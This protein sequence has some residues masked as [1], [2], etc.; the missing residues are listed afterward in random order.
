[1]TES[2][3]TRFIDLITY[4]QELVTLEITVKK[5]EQE[6]ATLRASQVKIVEHVEA[7]KKAS[8]DAQKAVDEKELEMATLVQ[9]ETTKKRRL[10]NVTNH[11]EYQSIKL[12][13][14]ALNTQQSSL[15]STLLEAWDAVQK[16]QKTYEQTQQSSHAQLEKLNEET[17][18]KQQ[19]LH[20]VQ[21]ELENKK[22][23]RSALES[24]VPAEWLEK[25]AVMRA[26]VSDPVVPVNSGSCSACFYKI[27]EQDLLLLGRNK[28]LQCKGCYRFLYLEASRMA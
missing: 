13:I 16:A 14:D 10:E 7:A 25:Y 28:L 19:Q 5:L 24:Q 21:T 4:D 22:A 9:A 8:H 6:L 3:F 17:A 20:S 27:P 1:M 26:R 18:H 2:P 12:E 11:K 23:Q 15:E